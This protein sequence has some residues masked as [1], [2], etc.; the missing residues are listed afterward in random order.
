[1]AA[2]MEARRATQLCR[3]FT[4]CELRLNRLKSR[5]CID[6]AKDGMIQNK[7]VKVSRH[8]RFTH[9]KQRRSLHVR[10]PQMK[11]LTFADAYGL[12]LIAKNPSAVDRSEILEHLS[13]EARKI[14]TAIITPGAVL[15]KDIKS[16][17][18]ELQKRVRTGSRA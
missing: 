9:L 8:K 2:M 11:P 15:S 17:A 18:K 5:R 6:R 3:E 13:P 1:M 12:G 7:R 4:L 14:A 16:A 10:N